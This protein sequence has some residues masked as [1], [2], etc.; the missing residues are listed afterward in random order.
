MGFVF[1]GALTAPDA[2]AAVSTSKLLLNSQSGPEDYVFTAADSVYAQG[3][4]DPA[5]TKH[6]GR[7]YRFE[8]RDPEGTVRATTAC[9]PNGKSGGTV[10]GNYTLQPGDPISTATGWSVVLKQYLD[11]G[12]TKSEASSQPVGF[13]VAR[14]TPYG[15]ETLTTQQDFFGTGAKSYLAIRG[16]APSQTDWSTTWLAPGPVSACANTQ[17]GD[18]P[19]SNSSGVLPA[20]SGSFLQ[21]AP[22]TSGSEW[23]LEANYD[24]TCGAFSPNNEGR[25]AVRLQG[26][27][28]HFVSLPVFSVD[29]TPPSSS[30]S[31]PATSTATGFSVS[32][33][34]S[35]TGAGSGLTKVD[36]YAKG[37]GETSYSKVATDSSPSSSGSFS[38]NADK[39]LG[40]YSFYTV[41]TDK[42]GNA[43]AAPDRADSSTD[44]I[45]PDTTPPMSSASAPSSASTNSFSVSYTALD[46]AGGS[47][48]AKVELYAKGP[49][50][51]SYQR[52]TTDSSGAG[53]GAFT[54]SATEGNG[55]Y[56]FYMV[57]TDRAGNVEAAPT[58]PDATTAVNA[59]S[60]TGNVLY[61]AKNDSSCS[62]S[63][64]G[65]Q[66]QPFCSIKPAAA[67]AKAGDTVQVD[68]GSYNETVTPSSS[69]TADA[70]VTFTSAPG[71]SPKV[72]G[73]ANGV[74]I[75]GL[76]YVTVDGF[77][78]T[79]TTG[80]AIILKSS[81]H[82]TLRNNHVSYAG[83]PT[84]GATAKGI[85]VEGTND[86]TV[87][88]NVVDH[89]TDFGVYLLSSSTRNEISGNQVASNARGYTR[90][91]SG[92][93]LYSAP[94][95]TIE[96]NL[97]HHNED[98]GIESYTGSS[99]ETIVN[100]V[101]YSNGDHGI[102]DYASSGQRIVSNTV[103]NNVT[104]GINLEA[105]SG[106]SAVANNMS[107]DNGI[108]SP[109]TTGDIRVD[110]T[111]TSGT[112]IDYD[113][114]NLRVSG[115]L[116]QWSDGF[117]SSLAD[118]TAATGQEAHGKQADPLWAGPLSGDFH[119]RSG[120]PAIDS[121]NSAASGER[122][123]D[124]E[125]R[126]RRDD[127]NTPNSG[128]GARPYDDRGAYEF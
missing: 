78:V 115:T 101:T 73:V 60:P 72:T 46:E 36:L 107:V 80:D 8:Y 34:A 19:D 75:L 21:Y 41:A 26:D 30:A 106:G 64:S 53:S 10:F 98:S 25:W 20:A 48:L 42:A 63:G 17:G 51:A 84:S 104:A 65:T 68:S 35:E 45:A 92:I 126:A 28:T 69:G 96:A 100:N 102:D 109:R 23:N 47:G 89:N 24:G 114:V 79:K 125:G 99:N 111:S 32:Y 121:G 116:F 18:R 39:G 86:S 49:T 110:A 87:A 71:A 4:V 91:A 105:S 85:R 13:Y 113:L 112:T 55:D 29:A 76:A 31:S 127:P 57:A 7:S 77:D 90:A 120:S 52:V 128:A 74:Y 119:L 94:G 117:Y 43:E 66:S 62:D 37:P 83:Q 124:A 97:T 27:A 61:V 50:D 56:A 59:P 123:T 88:N 6:R 54:Y 40:T 14:A 122:D 103:Y 38:Y 16:L 108:S 9:T 22:G 58:D 81:S 33:S 93:R 44:L 70:P 12:C 2:R 67:K 1:L 5:D 118:L 82:I 3:T 95:N 11:K 15:D